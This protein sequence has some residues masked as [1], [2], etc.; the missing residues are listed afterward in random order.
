[1]E[2]EIFYKNIKHAIE[3]YNRFKRLDLNYYD[4]SS[5]RPVKSKL[6][7]SLQ[8]KEYPF[9]PRGMTYYQVEMNDRHKMSCVRYKTASCYEI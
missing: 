5:I 3:L 7:F 2:F 6:L 1:M 9:C 4:I 8:K